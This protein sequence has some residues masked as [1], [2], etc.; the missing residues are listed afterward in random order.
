M[1]KS[2]KQ[3]L[4]DAQEY[5]RL[6]EW[7]TRTHAGGMRACVGPFGRGGCPYPNVDPVLLNVAHFDKTRRE[8]ERKR[9]MRFAEQQGI[10][11]PN[12]HIAG[13][14]YLSVLEQAEAL[15]YEIG[16]RVGWQCPS[17][18]AEEAHFKVFEAR[19]RVRDGLKQKAT[20]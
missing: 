20:E 18:N 17:C 14:A 19:R 16:E 11:L 6:A 12:R 3:R 8:S 2:D 4:K 10:R 5:E 7:F 13:Q 15:D 9:L 1:V